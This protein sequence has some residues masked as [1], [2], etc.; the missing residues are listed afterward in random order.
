MLSNLLIWNITNK[1]SE[2]Y[3]FL[4]YLRKAMTWREKNKVWFWEKIGE[5]WKKMSMK[6]YNYCKKKETNS[7][8]TMILKELEKRRLEENGNFEKRQLVKNEQEKIVEKV[9]NLLSFRRCLEN[10]EEQ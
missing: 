2:I 9:L 7:S 1:L 3:Y 5:F 6:N 8:K 4:F 10:K